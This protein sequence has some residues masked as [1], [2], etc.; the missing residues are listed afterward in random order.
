MP[1]DFITGWPYKVL[2]GEMITIMPELTI[3]FQN[4]ARTKRSKEIFENSNDVFFSSYKLWQLPAK[5]DDVVFQVHHAII[6][7]L[8]KWFNDAPKK[9]PQG[10]SDNDRR[11]N[12]W[13]TREQHDWNKVN[14]IFATTFYLALVDQVI[15]YGRATLHELKNPI[16][17][18]VV[19]AAAIMSLLYLGETE[20]DL[21]PFL[22]FTIKRKAPLEQRLDD[23]R[24]ADF[25][26]F[27]IFQLHEIPNNFW[28][29]VL[30]TIS[31]I[32]PKDDILF[33][34][35]IYYAIGYDSHLSLGEQIFVFCLSNKLFCPLTLSWLINL[36]SYPS[37]QRSQILQDAAQDEE[38]NTK[39][40]N[41]AQEVREVRKG[42]SE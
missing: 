3:A 27:R 35:L 21:A 34:S 25:R 42:Y 39:F 17:G 36:P 40:P 15:P 24:V 2:A 10:E 32:V 23:I 19:N 30:T 41:F 14:T 8:K 28:K 26:D 29:N 20:L 7:L 11:E 22:R 31:K 9:F 1:Q 18:D 37:Q 4:A 33:Q 38:F 13:F 12:I 5:Y 16:W 6:P